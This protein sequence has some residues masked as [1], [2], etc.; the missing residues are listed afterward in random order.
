M[1]E[2]GVWQQGSIGVPDFMEP[3]IDT[4]QSL[5]SALQVVIAIL[6][7]VLTVLDILKAFL[8][9]LLDPLIPL[10]EAIISDIRA[11]LNSIRQIGAYFHGDMGLVTPDME[12]FLGGF[13]AYQRRM[14]AR[15]MDRRDPNRPDFS[16][17]TAAVAFFFYVSVEFDALRSIHQLLE[18]FKNLFGIDVGGEFLPRCSFTEANFGAEGAS[19][20]TL[21]KILSSD[22]QDPNNPDEDEADSSIQD[23]VTLNWTLNAP[24]YANNAV[25]F[26]RVPPPGFLIMVSTVE[27][28]L[29]LQWDRPV[30]NNTGVQGEGELVQERESGLVVDHRKKTLSLYGGVDTID[31]PN[32]FDYNSNIGSGSVKDGG[33]RVYAVKSSAD[34][35]VIPISE[36]KKGDDYIFQRTFYVNTSA[37]D[38]FS[39]NTYRISLNFN[40]LPLDADIEVGSDGKITLIPTGRPQTYYFRVVAV[41]EDVVAS[42]SFKWQATSDV[43]RPGVPMPLKPT[44]N[45]NYTP[46][47]IGPVSTAF[48]V[49]FPSENSRRFTKIMATALAVMLLSRS[50]IPIIRAT[51]DDDVLG[52]TKG[53][54]VPFSPYAAKVPTGLEEV[55]QKIFKKIIEKPDEYFSQSGTDPVSFR[56]D[57][58]T[59]V[60][61]AANDFFGLLGPTPSIEEAVLESGDFLLDWKWTDASTLGSENYPDL[62]IYDS[63]SLN[64]IGRGLGSNLRSIGAVEPEV[65]YVLASNPDSFFDGRAP[66]F[67]DAAVNPTTGDETPLTMTNGLQTDNSPVIYGSNSTTTSL[68]TNVT[69]TQ[70][71]F[72]RNAFPPEVYQAALNVLTLSTGPA[73]QPDQDGGWIAKRLFPES[74]DFI[75][76]LGDLLLEW[77]QDF[78]NGLEGISSAIRN[79]I[80]GIQKRIAELQ[81]FLLRLDALLGI[82]VEF[83][84]PTVNLLPVVA[85]GT[86]GIVR[87][88]ITAEN[89][90]FDSP[91]NYGGGVVLVSGGIPNILIDLVTQLVD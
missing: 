30:P 58:R 62:T 34:I 16:G 82:L 2:L 56:N 40:E 84:F 48:S 73:A 67:Y 17:E 36:M 53:E 59:R 29:S 63:L 49:T 89:A 27:D 5:R 46:Q 71:A 44:V 14:L 52:I 55:S 41:S 86:D 91:E 69:Q 50:D 12:N 74:L 35:G 90:P 4:I 11:F 3:V 22:A 13:T 25:A 28:G 70:A 51:Q 47:A 81:A 18:A 79:Y 7:I 60:T 42:N 77:A 20:T 21:T 37:V 33:H 88:L 72:A 85:D 68:Y 39:N 1:A 19:L 54:I 10:L 57:L 31:I 6:D 87:E 26:P 32:T 80:E 76:D 38:F 65:N 66:F 23:I 8:V 15:L 24:P 78:V 43:F 83:E 61:N 75:D 9:G 64:D 45:N